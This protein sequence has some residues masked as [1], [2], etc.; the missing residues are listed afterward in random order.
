MRTT[1]VNTKA[2]SSL[3][4][5]ITATKK[6]WRQYHLT[7]DQTHYVAKAVR[8]AL[9]IERPK[10]RKHVV[11]R[12]SR[13]EERQ[14]IAHAYRVQG[15]RGLLIKTL[16]QTGARVSEFVNIKADE[17]FFEEQMILISKAKGGK[18]RYVPILPQLAQELRTHLGR[19]TTGYLFETVQHTHYSP[20]RIQQI[21]KETAAEAEITKRVYPHL[22]RHSVATT[23]LE[24]GMPIEQIQKF[25]G[26]AKL[27]TTQ[28]YAE[29]SA[30]MLKESYQRALAG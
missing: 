6:L 15:T 23:L 12:L 11:A 27:E 13:E 16:F 24:R 10:T 5:V 29:S 7:Y 19:R 20:R 3:L 30:E 18:S 14:L 21:I 26:H 28:I 8:R 25:L 1:P 4:P 9:A 22:L 17:V 2:S